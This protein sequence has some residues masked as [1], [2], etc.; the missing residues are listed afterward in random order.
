MQNRLTF[1]KYFSIQTTSLCNASCIFCPYKNIRDLFS[2][3]TMNMEL[4]KK[5]IDECGNY[6]KVERIIL[7]MNNEPLMDLRLAERIDYAK[8]KM[9]WISVHILTN[10]LLLTDEIAKRLIDSKLDWI[11]ISFHGI[12]KETIER[13]MGIPYE[14]A[15]ERINRFIERIKEKKNIKEYIMIT[16]LKH[17]YLTLDE[18][19]ATVDFWKS[20]G[21]KRIS[22]FD[23]PISRAGNVKCLPQIYHKKRIIACGSIWADEMMHIVEDGKVVLCC[24]DWKRDIVLGDL[25]KESIY[26]VWNGKRKN[27]W[28]MIYGKKEMPADF[29]CRKCEAAKLEI[30]E[31]EELE[32]FIFD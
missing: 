17:K 23:G 26:E 30:A 21:I 19:K 14:I 5:I 11:G 8:E 1:P 10:G 3:E 9:P 31:G 18:K 15:L 20:K 16:F 2:T 6:K 29:L 32:R 12:R 27:V 22:Y 25:S 13:A 28:Q 24:M 7:Y 4:Y